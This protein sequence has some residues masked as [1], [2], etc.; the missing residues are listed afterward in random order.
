MAQIK[1][2]NT[3][4]A[5]GFLK[6]TGGYRA[7]DYSELQRYREMQDAMRRE[8]EAANKS[9]SQ[10][11]EPKTETVEQSYVPTAAN[12]G[13]SNALGYGTTTP[14]ASGG[15]YSSS[16]ASFKPSNAYQQAMAY[17]NS[18]L[19]KLSSGR[20]AYSDKIDN[21]M[22]QIT[23]R[24]PFQYD[25][26]TDTLFQN[27]LQSAMRDGKVAMQ[28]TMG[29]A[30]ALTGGYGSTY[31]TSAANQAYNGYIQDAYK[32]LPDYYN[33]AMEAYNREG[34][35]L[36]NQ[37][38]AYQDLDNAEYNRLANAYSSNLQAAAQMYDNEYNNYWQT[39]NFNENSRKWA[40]E[41][42]YKQ[43]QADVANQQ[44]QDEYYTKYFNNGNSSDEGGKDPTAAQLKDALKTY[45]ETGDLTQWF[46][47]QNDDLNF[48]KVMEYIEKW[49]NYVKPKDFLADGYEAFMNMFK[50]K[51]G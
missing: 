28:D 34:Q 15:N 29:Q 42:A 21:L 31:A 18:L 36:Y 4:M 45:N 33:L 49:G 11:S 20:T 47:T 5:D 38:G 3:V 37:L 1:N 6:G 44:W 10:T 35:D 13:A 17:T 8:K 32:N 40:E 30:A 12:I 19:E 22:N 41:M 39:Q 48:E 23:N 9:S 27:S 51:R 25:A 24:Q 16:Q 26:D 7:E 43:S 2:K 14:G 46:D 50:S